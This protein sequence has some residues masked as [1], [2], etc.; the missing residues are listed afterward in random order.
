MAK[1]TSCRCF[2]A[3]LDDPGNEVFAQR[4]QFN[5]KNAE[6][7]SNVFGEESQDG[8]QMSHFPEEEPR[9]HE[10]TVT[11]AVAAPQP[12][13]FRGLSRSLPPAGVAGHRRAARK[14]ADSIFRPD[15]RGLGTPGP[16]S[17]RVRSSALCTRPATNR[18]L[19]L[20]GEGAR[21]A[22]PKVWESWTGRGRAEARQETPGAGSAG[23]AGGA[24]EGR[25]GA[26]PGGAARAA[27]SALAARPAGT[28]REEC[29]AREPWDSGTALSRSRA[30]GERQRRPEPQRQHESGRRGPTPADAR[31]A[32]A[33]VPARAM[34]APWGRE[35]GRRFGRRRGRG[36]LPSASAVAAAGLLCTALAA[37]CCWRQLPPLPW[38]SSAPPRPVAVLLWWEPFAG[39]DSGARPPPDC[40]LRF[41]ISGC[42]LLTDRAAYGEA[43]AVLFHHRDLVK[44]PRDW[45][46][47][48]GAPVRGADELEL[49]VLDD[50]E[51]VA[52]EALATSGLRPPG[53]RWVWMNFESP[54]HSPG[55]RNL[56]GNLFNWTLSYR[57]DS[58]VFV[59]YGYLYPRTHPSDQ[60]LGLAPPLARKRG[61]VAWVVSNWD[62]RQAR[63]RYYH[64]LS[65]HVSVDVFGRSGP[66]RPVPSIGLLHTVARYKFYLAFENSQ[67]LDY[68]TEKL[69][70][71]AL[72]AGAV[73]VVLGPDRANYERF[74]PRG[75]F[76]HV[77][78]FP[79]ASSLAAYLLFLDRNPAV[80]RRYFSWRRSYA[81]HITSFWEEPWCRACQ[82][83]QSAGDR[84]KS[85]RNL[86]RWFER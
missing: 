31:R 21:A 28:V 13:R 3:A 48:W 83:V 9:G 47:P 76:I 32:A 2:P 58:D 70:R 86:A 1:F 75:A 52:A 43:Q 69:W 14:E 34:G 4:E 53:Q 17:P 68:I 42:R 19:P 35:A 16:P 64:Q 37:F 23:R 20:E 63:V 44:E 62:E 6:E 38:A 61:L 18:V 27:H 74:M 10:V 55:L 80:Y 8:L 30:G 77:D 66:G 73:P 45:P 25:D 15:A 72:L 59:P 22:R 5:K 78:D 33:A 40:W 71:N 67:H 84:P 82:A 46:P 12:A 79:S 29:Q 41:N 57:A 7:I 81:V 56:A 85:I 54:S 39:R 51:A 60:P 26:A 36:L 50:E 24:V 65:Q 49:R 11:A